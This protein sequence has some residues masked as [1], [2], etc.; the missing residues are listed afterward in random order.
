M[1]DKTVGKRWK[2][3][4][5]AKTQETGNFSSIDLYETETTPGGC[6]YLRKRMCQQFTNISVGNGGA[7]MRGR[8]IAA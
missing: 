8:S 1:R 3:K 7:K 5:C 2:I 4:D 6:G